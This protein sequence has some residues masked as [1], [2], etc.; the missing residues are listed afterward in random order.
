MSIPQEES[1]PEPVQ[2]DNAPYDDPDP[3]DAFDREFLF[4]EDPNRN[5]NTRT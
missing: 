5:G 2:I 4:F 3:R 1:E